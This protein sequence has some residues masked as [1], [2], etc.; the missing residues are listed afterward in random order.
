MDLST[1]E[2]Q[3]RG[4][5]LIQRVNELRL[6]LKETNPDKLASLTGIP[7]IH[8]DSQGIFDFQFLER[9]LRLNFPNL[10]LFQRGSDDSPNPLI[11]ALVFYYFS[12]ADGKPLSHRWISFS[13]LPNGMFYN[14]AFQGYTGVTLAR[15][16]Q[17]DFSHFSSCAKRL[18]GKSDSFGDTAFR[19]Q[20]LPRLMLLVASWQGDDDFPSSFK[21]LFDASVSHYMPTDGCAIAGSMLTGMLLKK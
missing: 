7:F 13:E 14:Q 3:K 19:F 16:Y 5:Q 20:L 8:Q 1:I 12:T 15:F 9:P 4:E 11:Q 18:G 6:K 2:P 21:I 10:E 17:N